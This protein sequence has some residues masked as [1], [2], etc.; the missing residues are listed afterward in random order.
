LFHES[1]HVTVFVGVY[2]DVSAFSGGWVFYDADEATADMLIEHQTWHGEILF[3]SSDLAPLSTNL[4]D[5]VILSVNDETYCD[6]ALCATLCSLD[7]CSCYCDVLHCNH[8]LHY[9]VTRNFKPDVVHFPFCS[10]AFAIRSQLNGANG[11]H[12]GS[13]DI[14]KKVPPPSSGKSRANK[15]TPKPASKNV[16]RTL[17]KKASATL[18]AT[19]VKIL[20]DPSF[21][22]PNVDPAFNDTR[23]TKK[24]SALPPDLLR[25]C[26]D[27]SECIVDKHYH[28]ISDFHPNKRKPLE[29]AARR[30]AEK[31]KLCKLAGVLECNLPTRDCPL[32][33]LHYHRVDNEILFGKKN[34]QR[35]T[36]HDA[37]P[38]S[39]TASFSNAPP[40]G[41]IASVADSSLTA[42]TYEDDV[43]DS[44]PT[45]NDDNDEPTGII[46]SMVIDDSFVP[47]YANTFRTFEQQQ[48]DL[49]IYNRHPPTGVTASL[50]NFLVARAR[51][52]GFCLYHSLAMLTQVH[53]NRAVTARGVLIDIGNYLA[54]EEHNLSPSGVDWSTALRHIEFNSPADF[55]R[56]RS[57]RGFGTAFD[58]VVYAYA[59]GVCVNVWMWSTEGN[60]TLMQ[61][62]DGRTSKHHV[63]DLL[64]LPDGAGHYDPMTRAVDDY[65]EVKRKQKKSPPRPQP[66]RQANAPQT[67]V[68]QE[69]P[70]QVI[71]PLHNTS[72]N[73]VEEHCAPSIT[74][75]PVAPIVTSNVAALP[76]PSVAPG[77]VTDLDSFFAA[78][79]DF[80][81][82]NL[83]FGDRKPDWVSYPPE[84]IYHVRYPR[85]T[86]RVLAMR[87]QASIATRQ[88]TQFMRDLARFMF[89]W[90]RGIFYNRHN[91]LS[92]DVS[93]LSVHRELVVAETVK[94]TPKWYTK[95]LSGKNFS[96][97]IAHDLD[98]V[99][100]AYDYATTHQVDVFEDLA[101]NILQTIMET[102][103][104]VMTDG[105]IQASFVM[106]VAYQISKIDRRYYSL[107]CLPVTLNTEMFIVNQAIFAAYQR[108]M[109]MSN[110]CTARRGGYTAGSISIGFMVIDSLPFLNRGSHTLGYARLIPKD[111]TI[112]K[113]YT[114]NDKFIVVSGAEFYN[115]VTGVLHFPTDSVYNKI[116][117]DYKTLG[118]GVVY[119][120]SGIT[121]K[122]SNSNLSEALQ[123]HT[124]CRGLSLEENNASFIRQSTFVLHH[125][126]YMKSRLVACL[127][128]PTWQHDMREEA[129]KLRDTPHPKK[130]LRKAAIDSMIGDGRWFR[131]NW[132]TGFTQRCEFKMK[133][134]ETAKSG[135]YGRIIVDIGVHG[136]LHGATWTKDMKQY[137]SS[138]DIRLD[139]AIFRFCADPRPES[140]SQ[141]FS[142]ISGDYFSAIPSDVDIILV[143]FSDDCIFGRR[144]I[145]G[146]VLYNGDISSCDSSHG[147]AIFH[148]MFNILNC[149]ASVAKPL[150]AQIMAEIKIRSVSKMP[151]GKLRK[152]QRVILRPTVP[153]LQSGHTITTLVNT[154]CWLF[155]LRALSVSHDPS[156]TVKQVQDKIFDATGYIVELDQCS[157]VEDLQFL[158]QSPVMM[159]DGKYHA[160]V[161]LGVILR[162][163]GQC[164]GDLPG[165]GDIHKRSA[166]FQYE[167]MHAFLSHIDYPPLHRLKPAQRPRDSEAAKKAVRNQ[168]SDS[169]AHFS[170]S[171]V[172]P[173]TRVT[174]LADS[175]YKRYRLTPQ[176]IEELEKTYTY[177]TMTYVNTPGSQAILLKDYGL[178]PVAY[179]VTPPSF[180]NSAYVGF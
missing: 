100:S 46:A 76:S 85:V 142:F 12:T 173:T 159:T 150:W 104:V 121:L 111:V 119:V 93:V 145:S 25:F 113:P 68:T 18:Q 71:S 9:G 2:N 139:N 34:H 138:A 58:V 146:W 140:V 122:N 137:L 56:N 3:Q 55:F 149:P 147:I 62:A 97:H 116:D 164:K 26:E 180:P 8:T 143:A 129:Y 174:P 74:V 108:M 38:V 20:S 152:D 155:I 47:V 92:A 160:M 32:S 22:P 87:L 154:F 57:T 118:C 171:V 16:V 66:K 83:K 96:D 52:D 127:G 72:H 165:S 29:G 144:T 86:K 28:A 33:S 84:K 21:E 13:D 153:Y 90:Y 105:A 89:D 98:V 41:E 132:Y 45:L 82:K 94:H 44:T 123:R 156:D 168:L 91:C 39:A 166:A 95:L 157:I 77:K 31:V 128:V 40:T 112:N 110:P 148:A 75:A 136:S 15:T 4:Y 117:Y 7:V 5:F 88:Q 1:G 43:S 115:P 69:L 60:L 151:N 51:G 125:Y 53:E 169:S 78:A 163:S 178:Q 27:R 36:T 170:T 124:S 42:D 172:T 107:D 30:H 141:C 54:R 176:E 63:Y 70:A 14:K 167:L 81:S 106:L 175:F 131:D 120:H 114:F 50:D 67:P 99:G 10:N 126:S 37:A 133:R 17:R 130:E 24:H 103:P 101:D 80:L 102:S 35:M 19:S 64:Y 158:K 161:N 61:T 49:S 6:N 59:N 134:R 48:Y 73:L 23:A 109:S 65:V 135:K 79:V 162:A 179:H 177:S 11:E